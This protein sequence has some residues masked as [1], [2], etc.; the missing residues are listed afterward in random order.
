[1]LEA[2][3]DILKAFA[4]VLWTIYL[5][6]A[7][8]VTK[9]FV[10]GGVVCMGLWLLLGVGLFGENPAFGWDYAAKGVIIFRGTAGLACLIVASFGLFLA[11]LQLFLLSHIFRRDKYSDDASSHHE[12]LGAMGVMGLGLVPL[13]GL[14]WLLLPKSGIPIQN[15]LL[16]LIPVAMAFLAVWFA[17]GKFYYGVNGRERKRVRAQSAS[18]PDPEK[19]AREA[20][21]SIRFKD[22]YGNEEIK[23]RLLD[24]AHAIVGTRAEREEHAAKAAKLKRKGKETEPMPAP[25]KNVRNGILLSGEPGNGKTV[26]A[27]ALAGELGLPF[28]QL[29]YGDVVS[30]Y[31]GARTE[32]IKAAFDQAARTQ[33]CVL[34]IDEIDSF[35][36]DRGERGAAYTVKEDLD[37]VNALL[38]L[39]VDIRKANVVV[40][41]AT[42][43]V[44]RLDGAAIR[45][46]RFDFKVEI[47]PPDEAAR[48]GLLTHGVKTNLPNVEVSPEVISTVASRW[49]GFSVK[50]ILAVTEE[51]PSY[52]TELAE[53][54]QVPVELGFDHFMAALRRLQGRKGA[55]PENVKPLSE[56]ILPDDTRDALEMIASRLRDPLRTER[57]GGT[58]PTGILFYGPPGTGKTAVAKALAKDIGC[59]FLSATGA[60][61][62]RDPKE[63]ERLYA[64]AKELRPTIIFIDEGDELLRSRKYSPSTEATN[65]LLTLME[66]VQDRV[67]DVVWIAATNHPDQ[68][69]EALL[70]GGR[71]TEKVEFVRPE[72]HQIVGY[73]KG[74]LDTRQLQLDEGLD[75]A[76][77]AA[78][79]GGESVA[80]VEAVLQYA[81]NRAISKAS[82]DLVRLQERDIKAALTTVLGE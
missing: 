31:V 26:F 30:Q 39:L 10:V 23:R 76:K 15:H 32:K 6:I 8:L 50:R 19:V 43:Y 4:T 42:N 29:T 41:A 37:S 53:K 67:R 71:F 5:R 35:I 46:G 60:D 75:A 28:L 81:V 66:G 13:Y 63:L 56:M 11:H 78:M 17:V 1:M 64:K 14:W 80:N 36:A 44:D 57:L 70:R 73:I 21:P 47:T 45:E 25:A 62:A 38:T 16:W 54:G 24:A 12:F 40:I 68:I 33:P 22:I 55:T 69:D 7:Y 52:L 27:E 61:L 65:K 72:E 20:V 49:N 2:L 34:F 51:M 79:I 82:G 3:L 58:L 18:E 48:I 74:W 9:A 59:A 77:L